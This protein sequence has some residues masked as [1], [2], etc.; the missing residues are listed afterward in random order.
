MPVLAPDVDAT[1][2]ARNLRQSESMPATGRVSG[3]VLP[4][5]PP[6]SAAEHDGVVR[7]LQRLAGPACGKGKGGARVIN[8]KPEARW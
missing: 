4:T 3:I 7:R 6:S 2:W 1:S 8:G 5:S